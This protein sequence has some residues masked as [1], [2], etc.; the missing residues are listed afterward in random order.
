[1]FEVLSNLHSPWD[2]VIPFFTDI[3]L[4][5][6]ILS[7]QRP[8]VNNLKELY[9]EEANQICCLIS[10][11]WSD[12]PDN[13]PNATQALEVFQSKVEDAVAVSNEI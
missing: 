5:D 1:M 3:V 11:C 8:N 4:K 13:R 2:G 6:K 7:G 10:T 9:G 12:N